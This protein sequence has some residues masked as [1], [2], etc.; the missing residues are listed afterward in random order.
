MKDWDAE[1]CDSRSKVFY[2]VVRT[3]SFSERVE[4]FKKLVATTEHFVNSFNAPYLKPVF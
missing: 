3:L 4:I 1:E 2:N